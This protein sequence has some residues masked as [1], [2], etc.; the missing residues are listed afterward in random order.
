M[1]SVID[2]G[3]SIMGVLQPQTGP[4][5]AGTITVT[6]TSDDVTVARGL[7]L[8]PIVNGR[9]RADLIFVVDSGPNDDLS[10]TATS[11]GT[12][13]TVTSN[14]GGGRHNL[15]IGTT[16]NFDLPLSGITVAVPG[17]TAMAGA[18][19]PGIFGGIKSM[20]LYEQFGGPDR[21]LDLARSATTEFPAVVIAW[22][23][24]E[25]ADGSTI[26]QTHRAT[27]TG[28]RRAL[29]KEAFN[30][31]VITSRTES[32]NIR[33]QEGHVILDQITMLLTDRQEI[34]GCVFSAPSGTQVRMRIREGGPQ[35]EYQ[36]FYIYR[37]LVSCERTYEQID[38]RVFNDWLTS[39]IDSEL[40]QTPALPNQG[41][42]T[43]V[44]GMEVDMRPGEASFWTDQSPL[45]TL[46]VK[47][48]VNT[49]KK[50]FINWGDGRQDPVV[51]DGTEKTLSHD[52]A[53]TVNYQITISGEADQITT[54]DLSSE[55]VFGNVK[56]FADLTALTALTLNST[57]VSYP[58]TATLADWTGSTILLQDCALPAAQ[59]DLFLIDLDS[60][61]TGAGTLNIA[62]TNGT[63]T[64]ASDTAKASLVTKGWT[65]TVNE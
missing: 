34:N 46:D 16:F 52:Y 29:Y 47:I 38:S 55:S 19:A 20:V 30:I 50:V 62:G 60:D 26:S 48:T 64:S 51:A 6:A 37:I 12:A 42:F 21:A 25:P 53:D 61:V 36:K 13:I 7:F 24:S 11:S 9:R 40:T 57:L 44:D 5:S 28:T 23:N 18:D 17:A 45:D 32:D 63:R 33:R 10:W 59:V 14:I 31:F 39:I 65:I 56:D 2:I 54:L 58:A 43:M 15:P 35:P 22:D 49:G 3:R 4:Q 41:D 1:P 8:I 27:R